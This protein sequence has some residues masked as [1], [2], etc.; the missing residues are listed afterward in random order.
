MT[1]VLIVIGGWVVGVL[2]ALALVAVGARGE[3]DECGGAT[4]HVPKCSVGE[5]HIGRKETHVVSDD[6][7]RGEVE[8]H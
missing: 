2:A 4:G 1:T 8:R 5:S 3:C 7:D 6:T